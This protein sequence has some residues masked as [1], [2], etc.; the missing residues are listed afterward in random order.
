MQLLSAAT[1]N[2]TY[3]IIEF[4]CSGVDIPDVAEIWQLLRQDSLSATVISF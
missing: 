1:A 4:T 3:A 2:K